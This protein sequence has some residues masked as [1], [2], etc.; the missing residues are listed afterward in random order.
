M[1]PKGIVVLAGADANASPH[2]RGRVAALE[3]VGNRPIVHYVIDSLFA[4][5]VR[6]IV[7]VSPAE[8]A[9]EVSDCVAA[10]E[11]AHEFIA[12]FAVQLPPLDLT[13]ALSAAA[14][15]IGMAPC[16][17]HLANGLVADPLAPFCD[18]L[19]DGVP[20]VGLL[21]H[22]DGKPGEQFSVATQ[23]LLHI[24]ALHA[25]SPLG[26]AGVWFFGEGALTEVIGAPWRYGS[27]VDLAEVSE[28]IAAV[29]GRL[30]VRQVDAWCGYAGD[31]L[32]LLELNRMALDSLKPELH[33]ARNNGNRIEGRVKIDVTAT[34]S[35][36]VVIG[37]TVIGPGAHIADSYIGPYT[38]VG[39]G[40]RIEGAEIER[41]IISPGASVMHV[42]GRLVSS[43]VG[44]DARVFRDFSLPRAM[45]LHLSDGAEVAL[46]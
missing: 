23:R 26:M 46:C 43:V 38:S 9:P 13:S 37:P 35:S 40:V 17:V 12:R 32:E 5:G 15:L 29:D 19:R 10:H 11:R 14:P 24:A 30:Q 44:R 36:S 31:A 41:S 20:D 16:I 18:Q 4:A 3:H 6:E 25:R 21:V 22:H 2:P 28:R 8:V 39:T 27:E 1:P 33:Q 34:V 7:V 42:G 45:R